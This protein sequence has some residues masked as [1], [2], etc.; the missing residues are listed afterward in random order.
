LLAVDRFGVASD[1]AERWARCHELALDVR[2]TG[3]GDKLHNAFDAAM[4]CSRS[5]SRQ[6]PRWIPSGAAAPRGKLIDG[7]HPIM[8]GMFYR[9]GSIIDAVEKRMKQ[10]LYDVDD[11]LARRAEAKLVGSVLDLS[12]AE[13]PE[14]AARLVRELRVSSFN[15]ALRVAKLFAELFKEPRFADARR[16]LQLTREVRKR[17]HSVLDADELYAPVRHVSRGTEPKRLVLTF[18]TQRREDFPDLLR[19]L[20]EDGAGDADASLRENFRAAVAFCEMGS[21]GEEKKLAFDDRKRIHDFFDCPEYWHVSHQTVKD[22]ILFKIK[23]SRDP[24]LAVARDHPDGLAKEMLDVEEAVNSVDRAT[25]AADRAPAP[26][27]DERRAVDDAA[28]PARP[29]RPPRAQRPPRP[30]PRE[31][32]PLSEM[33]A[34][35]RSLEASAAE[36]RARAAGDALAD[37]VEQ[38][39]VAQSYIA[40]QNAEQRRRNFRENN[41]NAQ[42]MAVTASLAA[43]ERDE[44]ERE[45]RE[46]RRFKRERERRLSGYESDEVKDESKLERRARDES[47]G[48]VAESKEEP[49]AEAAED[50]DEAVAASLA[51]SEADAARR[52]AAEDAELARALAESKR[53]AAS[54]AADAAVA[55]ADLEGLDASRAESRADDGDK[56]L[57]AALELSARE[58]SAPAPAVADGPGEDI[59]AV[60]AASL[61]AADADAAR[62]REI[63]DEA[64]A[65]AL[66]ASSAAAAPGDA[67]GGLA[68]ELR[69]AEEQERQL[70]ERQ[71]QAAE[72]ARQLR[73]RIADKENIASQAN[74]ISRLRDENQNLRNLQQIVADGLGRVTPDAA[75]STGDVAPEGYAIVAVL[76]ANEGLSGLLELFIEN[77]I[78]DEALALPNCVAVED[79]VELGVPAAAARRILCK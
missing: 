72:R 16:E 63:E 70:A 30:P 9:Y 22:K 49:P 14:T 48:G 55:P 77:E 25:G 38:D 36:A 59:D 65:R 60:L 44:L 34:L 24:M 78:D 46:L 58:A 4:R 12:R 31:P 45:R 68:A 37:K 18:K 53:P 27:I 51:E 76:L 75:P 39:F 29:P 47:Q 57:L 19:L 54:L 23:W 32:E 67:A 50:L 69:D 42:R 26:E 6:Q 71:R 20:E 35:R 8:P 1:A 5:S 66:A 2:T 11:P 15:D 28:A 52:R 41:A 10:L 73:E 21:V 43:F 79:L 74:E 61:A 64:V 13:E 56:Q 62:R 3:R 17:L 7:N 33:E 40:E